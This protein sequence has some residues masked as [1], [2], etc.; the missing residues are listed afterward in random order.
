MASDELE[1]WN[2]P[3]YPRSYS[4]NTRGISQLELGH[5]A[6]RHLPSRILSPQLPWE[7]AKAQTGKLKRPERIDSIV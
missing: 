2:P 7:K 6:S 4:A 3:R 5:M 1:T